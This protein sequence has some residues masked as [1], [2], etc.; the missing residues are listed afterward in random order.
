MDDDNLRA[1]LRSAIPEAPDTTA[2]ADE[3]RVQ[4]GRRTRLAM[5]GA[6]SVLVLAVIGAIGGPM[7]IS[8][9]QHAVPAATP[10]AVGGTT[11]GQETPGTTISPT[12]STDLVPVACQ[13]LK[14]STGPLPSTAQR[15][16]LCPVGDLSEEVYYPL[17]TILDGDQAKAVLAALQARPRL[18]ADFCTADGGPSFLLVAETDGTLPAALNL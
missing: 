2:W 8:G 3:A 15:L 1:E 4:H 5:T 7:L 6:V 10:S 13:G 17:L 9:G 16:R 18:E 12:Q 14:L 11:A